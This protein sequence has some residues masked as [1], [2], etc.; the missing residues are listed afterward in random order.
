MEVVRI[1]ILVFK[2][3]PKRLCVLFLVQGHDF[4][5]KRRGGGGGEGIQESEM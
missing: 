4:V 3:L 2:P 5:E 1:V